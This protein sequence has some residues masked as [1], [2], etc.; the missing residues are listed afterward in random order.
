MAEEKFK[1]INEAYEVLG[2]PEKR[3]VDELGAVEQ[4]G[5]RP[6]PGWERNNQVED[7]AV[8]GA[9]MEGRIQFGGTGF[10][11]FFE[12][13]WRRTWIERFG[14]GSFGRGQPRGAG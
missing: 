2:D 10:S 6:P 14:G 7:S 12:A 13:F 9:G 5:V 11:D 4:P 1:Q 3:K 8:M